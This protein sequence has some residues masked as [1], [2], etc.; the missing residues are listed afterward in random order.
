MQSNNFTRQPVD[1]TNDGACSLCASC[2]SSILPVTEQEL[3]EMKAYADKIG[4][5]PELPGGKKDVI[6]LMC[7]FLQPKTVL[8][9]KQRCAIYD[10]R[11][12][13][14]RAFL[15]NQRNKET[16]AKYEKL[17]HSIPPKVLN[18]WKAYNKT[19]LRFKGVEIS[20][21]GAEMIGLVDDDG[22]VIS[23]QIGQPVNIVLNNNQYI[24]A[25]L[26]IGIME[27]GI[28]VATSDGCIKTVRFDDIN[29]VQV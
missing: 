18:V 7:P 11:P 13:I 3:S 12:N 28:Q 20:Y 16:K 2:C 25:A 26:C 6:Y 17:A 23:I 1:F 24:H 10:H 8:T 9:V 4:F 29:T 22:R 5:T 15:C 14:C 27:Y 19:G 21:D